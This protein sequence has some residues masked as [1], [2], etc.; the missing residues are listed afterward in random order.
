MTKRT[1][2]TK[3]IG[4]NYVLAP[5]LF[6]QADYVHSKVNFRRSENVNKADVVLLGLQL[7]F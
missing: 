7:S 6:L 5:G 4:V 1:M 2:I 3:G